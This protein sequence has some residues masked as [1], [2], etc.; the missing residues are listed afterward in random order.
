MK[1]PAV[2]DS[3]HGLVCQASS[4]LLHKVKRWVLVGRRAQRGPRNDLQQQKLAL[5]V[6]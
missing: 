5:D 2:E 4:A 6:L 1:H 3:M